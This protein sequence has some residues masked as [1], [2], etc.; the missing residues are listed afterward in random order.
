MESHASL[1]YTLCAC[2]ADLRLPFTAI[3]VPYITDAG[4]GNLQSKM[5]ESLL[6]MLSQ[7]LLILRYPTAPLSGPARSP[8]SPP[9]S[10]SS[11]PRPAVSRSSRSTRCTSR[12]CTSPSLAGDASTHPL[13]ACSGVPA[14]RSSSWTPYGGATARNREDRMDEAKRLKLGNETTHHETVTSR[15]LADDDADRV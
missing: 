2:P 1:C 13:H 3:I 15:N 9:T 5:Y 14:W 10:S 11:S 7:H 6:T 8:S 12:E 4:Y